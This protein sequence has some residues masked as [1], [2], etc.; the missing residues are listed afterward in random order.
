MR[1]SIEPLS[2]ESNVL[3]SLDPPSTSALSTIPDDAYVN[4]LSQVDA[5]G[6]SIASCSQSSS[7]LPI[8][9]PDEDTMEA[10]STPDYP[11]P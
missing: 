7:H 10:C 6:N 5:L 2:R 9:Q 11:Y 4:L 3:T 8:P 1:A